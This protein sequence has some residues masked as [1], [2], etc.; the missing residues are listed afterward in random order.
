MCVADWRYI[1]GKVGIEAVDRVVGKKGSP[2]KVDENGS[3]LL[4]VCLEGR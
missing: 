2:C 1:Y 3:A 4:S